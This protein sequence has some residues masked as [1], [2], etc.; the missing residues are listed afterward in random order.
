MTKRTDVNQCPWTATLRHIR[1]L[2]VDIVQQALSFALAIPM[3]V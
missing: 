3:H 2:S 1:V